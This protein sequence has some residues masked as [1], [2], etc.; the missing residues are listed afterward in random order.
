MTGIRCYGTH[1]PAYR[2]ARADIA[3]AVGESATGTRVVAGPGED[4]TTLGWRTLS[5]EHR[6]NAGDGCTNGGLATEVARLPEDSDTRTAYTVALH[7][8][9][10]AIGEVGTG[11]EGEALVDL[12]TLVGAMVLARATAGDEVSERILREVRRSLDRH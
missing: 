11:D 4:S 2:L 6:D 7:Q 9:V 5:V 3:A 10:A 1:L 8:M 12:S